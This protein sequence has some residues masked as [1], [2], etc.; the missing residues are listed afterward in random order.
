MDYSYLSNIGKKRTMNQDYVKVFKN[1]QNVLLFLLADGMGGH[2]A[3]DVAS[4]LTVETLGERWQATNFETGEAIAE[5]LD[6]E[7][8][9]L[10]SLV[11]EE[12]QKDAFRGMGTTIEAL[13]IFGCELILAHV[14]DSRSYLLRSDTLIQITEDHSL[15]NELRLLG[16]ITAEEASHHPRKNIITRSVGMP[17]DLNVDIIQRTVQS[18]DLFLIC[19]DGL[20]NMLSDEEILK[21][22]VSSETLEEKAEHLINQANEN[23]GL[24]NIT[25]LLIKVPEVNYD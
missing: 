25:V 22:L 18:N 19:S 15:V 13:C 1:L 10:N 20:S 17:N 23:G 11:F 21:L 4:K 12:G 7:I 16:E 3:G 8:K 24:D 9:Q 14:G 5:W 6:A 2:Q